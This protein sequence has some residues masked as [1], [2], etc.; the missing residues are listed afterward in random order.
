MSDAAL[1][2][3]IPSQLLTWMH[4]PKITV[5]PINESFLQ[6]S[7]NTK[8]R[9]IISNHYSAYQERV[10]AYLVLKSVELWLIVSIMAI[11]VN[12]CFSMEHRF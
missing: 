7:V 9:K 12:L 4:L 10:C 5:E 3:L 8:R 6:T 1:N 2:P 11:M